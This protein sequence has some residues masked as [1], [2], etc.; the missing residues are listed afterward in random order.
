MQGSNNKDV[1]FSLFRALSITLETCS[2][3]S[4]SYIRRNGGQTCRYTQPGHGNQLV[5]LDGWGDSCW[6]RNG[7]VT[8]QLKVWKG[9]NNFK[10][11]SPRV[12]GENSFVT[13]DR[14]IHSCCRSSCKGFVSVAVRKQPSQKAHGLGAD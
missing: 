2:Q 9:A 3:N 1:N 5:L 4:N 10:N 12:S 7:L 8:W 6:R 13:W 11:L 14:W